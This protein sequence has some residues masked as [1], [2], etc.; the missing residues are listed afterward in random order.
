[1]VSHA[2]LTWKDGHDP[3]IFT[4]WQICNIQHSI[5]RLVK[6]EYHKCCRHPWA[7]TW[8]RRQ[9]IVWLEMWIVW[10][11]LEARFSP[12]WLSRRLWS[13]TFLMHTAKSADIL[14]TQHSIR[15]WDG[16]PLYR[17]LHHTA[18]WHANK[19]SLKV[20]SLSLEKKLFHE[21]QAQCCV[22]V[23]NCT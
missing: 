14:K 21:I 20:K 15:I 22:Y 1:M 18:H 16:F 19:R 10:W 9:E 7:A 5:F 12:W 23:F 8:L 13:A 11:Q 2:C 6:K 3:H 17:D 4:Q